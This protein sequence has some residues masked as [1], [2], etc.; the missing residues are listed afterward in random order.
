MTMQDNNSTLIAPTPKGVL[1][2]ATGKPVGANDPFFGEINDELADKGFLV[3][4]TDEL[5]TWARTGSLMWMTFGLACCAV[6][7]MQ[8]SMPRYDAERFVE[9]KRLCT[10]IVETGGYDRVDPIATARRSM[11]LTLRRWILWR[12]QASERTM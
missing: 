11:M 4:S 2:P 12:F 10:E 3:T 8:L 1:D 5:I 9:F 6:E 7:M